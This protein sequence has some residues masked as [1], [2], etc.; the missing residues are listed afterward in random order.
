M[1]P[2]SI[3]ML[4]EHLEFHRQFTQGPVFFLKKAFSAWQAYRV[5]HASSC[6]AEDCRAA[7]SSRCQEANAVYHITS[8]SLHY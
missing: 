3:R 4:Y 7:E 6:A 8:L 1:C 2:P 5:G